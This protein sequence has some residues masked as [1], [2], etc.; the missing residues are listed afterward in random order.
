MLLKLDWVML[1]CIML[2]I[3]FGVFFIYSACHLDPDK[4]VRA[5]YKKQIIWAIV[6]LGAYAAL[7]IFDYRQLYEM[8]WVIYAAALVLLVLVLIVGQD[9]NGARRSFDFFNVNI[10]PSEIAKIATIVV[11][12]QFLSNTT[13]GQQTFSVVL[14]TLGIIGAPMLLILAEP[15]LGTALMFVPI[16]LVCTY[17]AGVPAKYLRRLILVGV[18]VVSVVVSAA[19]VPAK[20]NW[21]ESNQKLALKMVFLKDYQLDR[22]RNWLQP[23][24]DPLDGGY[25]YIQTRMAVGSG[26]LLGQGYLQG[27]AKTLRYLPNTVAPTD[28]ASHLAG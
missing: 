7:T 10:Q 13:A 28:H 19:V 23:E 25:A 18:V 6:G 12:A 26:G 8:S 21:S 27:K 16:V 22:F 15:D 9:I 2:L 5:L 14:T 3:T 24:L 1:L 11:L 20:L 4:P 17:V